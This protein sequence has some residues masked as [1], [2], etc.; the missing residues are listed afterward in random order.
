MERHPT[1]PATVEVYVR[2]LSPNEMPQQ[3]A[4]FEQL[5]RLSTR[6]II[7]YWTVHVVGKEVCPETATETR[8]GRIICDRIQQFKAWAEQNDMSFGKFFEQ[9][10][11]TSQMTG[12][13]Y[14]TMVLPSVTLA[15]FD[16]E[17]T[18]QFVTP[19]FE[20][21]THYTPAT[22]LEE[23]ADG[24]GEESEFAVNSH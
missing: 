19:S 11:V 22:R 15:E 5:N 16:E 20:G 8:P 3:Q 23:L 9:R 2:S 17:G 6:G 24:R 7:D 13:E 18:L 14:E 4:L 1:D 10:P 21:E 12:E